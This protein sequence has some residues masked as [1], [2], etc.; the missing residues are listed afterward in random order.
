MPISFLNVPQSDEL[1]TSR[2][3][4]YKFPTGLSIASQGPTSVDYLIVAGGGGGGSL[5][6][7]G[8]SVS[9]ASGYTIHTFTGDG[10]FSTNANFGS[11]SSYFI[12]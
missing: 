12:N 1:N 3:T 10:T 2:P 5:H 6:A 11:A 7:G 4:G 8:G 9:S